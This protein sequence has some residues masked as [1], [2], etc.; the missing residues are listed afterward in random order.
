MAPSLLRRYDV[1]STGVGEGW[2]VI[3]LDIPGLF[4]AAVSDYGNYAFQW[5]N[6]GDG[7]EF[8]KFLVGLEPDYLHGKLMHGRGD[9]KVFDGEA[10][11]KA[12][13]KHLME[14][15]KRE[16]PTLYKRE[17][18]RLQEVGEFSS[19]SDFDHWMSDTDLDVPWE[20]AVRIPEPQCMQFCTKTFARFKEMLTEELRV[21]SGYGLKKSETKE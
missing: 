19:Q 4:F 16:D 13:K 15:T 17:K 21:E 1:P 3:V 9:A 11:F 5:T 7:N 14:V 12:V 20:F 6:I 10:T 8:R 18:S 2:A